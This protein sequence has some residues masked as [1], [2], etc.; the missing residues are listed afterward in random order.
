ML[1]KH[2][3]SQKPLLNHS[4]K[5]K[6]FIQHIIFKQL[7]NIIIPKHIKKD[8]SY[9]FITLMQTIDIITK[10]FKGYNFTAYKSVWINENLKILEFGID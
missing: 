1:K 5:I 9:I 2:K 7:I 4:I 8:L 10:S 3:Y 6:I